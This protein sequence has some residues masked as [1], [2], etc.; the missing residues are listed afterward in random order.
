MVKLTAPI[1]EVFPPNGKLAKTLTIMY[2]LSLI[3]GIA[4]IIQSY[5]YVFFN[6][7]AIALQNTGRFMGLLQIVLL[8]LISGIQNDTYRA[9]RLKKKQLDERQIQVRRRI[10]EKSYAFMTVVS[11]ASLYIVVSSKDWVI[12][13]QLRPFGNDMLWLPFYVSLL[14]FALP[15]IF[16]AWQ[17][18]S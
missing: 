15:P 14:F 12:Q 13:M 10:L 18:D 17:K 8:P 9:I 16:A 6:E 7:R 1:H 4:A 2:I 11:I 5:N 3:V